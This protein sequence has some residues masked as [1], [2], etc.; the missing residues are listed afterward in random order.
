MMEEN[1]TIVN[2]RSGIFWLWVAGG[3]FT[4]GIIMAVDRSFF[5]EDD[6]WRGALYSF[7]VGAIW[8]LLLG[9]L[10][11]KVVMFALDPNFSFSALQAR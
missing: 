5:P 10:V 6:N 9:Y 4:I 2:V 3:L 1:K 11:G 8:P 7:A